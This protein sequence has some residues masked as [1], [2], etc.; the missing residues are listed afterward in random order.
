MSLVVAKDL[1]VA[2]VA[3]TLVVRGRSDADSLR[4]DLK[5]AGTRPITPGRRS[6]M[7]P[8][9]HDLAR[10]AERWRIEVM[11]CRLKDYRRVVTRQGKL[12][13][14]YLASV[15]PAAIASFWCE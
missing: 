13:A 6:R 2:E 14:N 1:A 12:A 10:H 3:V 7:R 5:A 15:Q 8:I 4:R 9:Q 11:F